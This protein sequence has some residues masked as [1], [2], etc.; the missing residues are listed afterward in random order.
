LIRRS[1]L[2][3][4]ALL[5]LL[6]FSRA[7]EEKKLAVYSPQ[8]NFTV[9]VFDH[10]GHEY[11]SLI[12][13]M[14]PFGRAELRPDK[15]RWRLK[16]ETPNGK[17]AEG[18]FTENSSQAK[19]RGKKLTL[20]AP[21]WMDSSRGYIPLASA[22][23]VLSQL[24]GLN[25]NLRE[26]SR[27]LFIG[28]VG[29]SYSVDLQKG[30]PSKLVLH[31]T[32]PVNP[33]ISTE[34]GKVR[35]TFTREPLVA[36]ANNPQTIDDSVMHSATFSEA[37]GASEI[38]VATSSPVLATF[39]DMNK[40]ITLAPAPV[41]VAQ[42]PKPAV[43]IPS[44]TVPVQPGP[45]IPAA[46]APVVQRFVVIIDPAHG[47]DDPGEALGNGLFEKDVTLAIA[48]RIRNEL[49]QRGLAAVLLREGDATLTADQR[50]VSANALR[51]GMYVAVHVDT[52]GSGVRLYSA[53][54]SAT[55][56]GVKFGFVPWNSAQSMYLD[57]S[58]N[59][60]AS[61]ISEFDSRR[62]RAVPLEAGLRP[63]RNITKPAI[64]VEVAPAEGNPDSL[65]LVP[66]QQ[67][68]ASAIAAGIANIRKPTEGGQ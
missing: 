57:Q 26:N 28:E 5:L 52:A 41:P 38:V 58:H 60:I 68:V 23:V 67:S 44:P 7:A 30:N 53:R 36:G 29:A 2:L 11:V 47:G 9:P 37:N 6:G 62:V 45:A 39:G 40:T 32:T 14:D 21:Y 42:A 35:L 1:Q 55:P 34:P 63:L 19:L 66:Y 22:H 56:Q 24:L 12:D 4:L 16:L 8:T 27:R 25:A 18:E 15:K 33:T 20:A 54:L 64:A 43:P 61:M 13:L 65:T 50:A 17:S 46:P 51:N 31:F 10:D 48:R 3:G 59:L 49:D